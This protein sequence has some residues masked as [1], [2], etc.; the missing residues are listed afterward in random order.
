MSNQMQRI[1]IIGGGITGLAAAHRL[2]EIAS[3]ATVRLFEQSDRLG[4][5]LTTQG[6]TTFPLNL[7]DMFTTS[8]PWAIGLCRRL[9]F[10]S[11]LVGPNPEHRR[12]F[13]VHRGR[14]VPIPVGFSLMTPSR[15]WPMLR[16]PLLSLKGKIRLAREGFIHPKTDDSDESLASFARRRLGA[17]TYERIVQPLVGGIYTADP[18]KLSMAATLDRFRKMEREH[19]SLI[20]AAIS[21]R[22]SASN[23]TTEAAGVRYGEFVTP[24]R[25][26]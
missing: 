12:A 11:Q 14:L 1:A 15:F 5:V 13:I 21:R 17:E 25:H 9:G 4:G 22:R 20:R 18:E 24:R 7:A 16:T 23:S 8:E 26:V 3:S 2:T 19:G 10:E 6:T